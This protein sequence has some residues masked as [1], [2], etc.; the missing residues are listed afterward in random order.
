VNLP[1]FEAH[2]LLCVLLRLWCEYK[3]LI[4][5]RLWGKG[6]GRRLMEVAH[7]YARRL[8]TLCT[9]LHGC[10]GGCMCVC[11]YG[12]VCMC[13][14]FFFL[15]Y[16]CVWLRMYVCLFLFFFFFCLSTR[17]SCDPKPVKARKNQE[18]PLHTRQEGFLHPPGLRSV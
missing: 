14:F 18:L 11:V 3:V 2:S 7:A 17:S 4:H 16:V 9:S 12:C 10:L 15:V 6:L 8:V 13:V 5:P 1:V